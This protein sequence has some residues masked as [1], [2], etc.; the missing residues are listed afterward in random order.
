MERAAALLLTLLVIGVVWY[1]RARA[2][3]NPKRPWVYLMYGNQF[4]PRTDVKFMTKR[5]LLQSALS[6]VLLGLIFFSLNI[7][8]GIIIQLGSD[9]RDPAGIFIVVMFMSA[10]FSGMGFLGASYLLVRWLF[11]RSSYVPP[12]NQ[13]G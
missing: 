5:E 7:A 2:E 6:F 1:L 11:R 3:Q 4:G 10:L 8:N 12:T 9:P 13:D